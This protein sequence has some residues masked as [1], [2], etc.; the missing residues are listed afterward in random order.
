MKLLLLQTGGTIGS[1]VS[2]GVIGTANA[3]LLSGLCPAGEFT[4]CETLYT[5]LS[6]NL[7]PSYWEKLIR[8]ISDAAEE[9][10]EG[11]IVAHG[12]DTLSYTGAMLALTLSSLKMPVIVTASNYVPED[13][14]SNAAANINAAVS[15]AKKADCGVY[16]VYKNDGSLLPQVWMPTRLR[17]ADRFSDTFTSSDGCELAVVG[18]DGEIIPVNKTLMSEKVFSD[19]RPAFRG[20]GDAVKDISFKSRVLMLHQYPGMDYG[21]IAVAENVGA[22]LMISYHSG[23]LPQSSG[24]LLEKCRKRGIPVFLCSVKSS[25]AN[26]YESTDSL[27]SSGMI[28]LF[29]ITDESAY[30]KLLIGLNTCPDR[31]TEFMNEEIYYENTSV[32]GRCLN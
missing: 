13:P 3:P 26:Y 10:Y 18:K 28:P 1:A 6:E 9:G 21:N 31:L 30:A 12:S 11:V 25:A 27:L 19:G 16:V 7:E 8:R 22:V 32:S 5:I 20:R 23:T 14:R 24:L 29:D 15:L 4:E 2:D 17:E